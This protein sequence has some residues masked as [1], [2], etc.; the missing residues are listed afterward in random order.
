MTLSLGRAVANRVDIQEQ[1]G[2][3]K[4]VSLKSKT[5][6]DCTS[7]IQIQYKIED[8]TNIENIASEKFL[9]HVN[10][11]R[12]LTKYLSFKIAQVLS[13]AGKRYVLPT[14]LLLNQ[15]LSI[16]QANLSFIHI[17]KLTL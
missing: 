7:G 13:A 6:E 8:D 15:K 9:S 2:V 10:T 14:P 3:I 12:D 4:R 1:K 11:K 17:R 16:F 5:R